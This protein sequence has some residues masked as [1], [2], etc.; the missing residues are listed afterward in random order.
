MNVRGSSCNIK[1][2]T[3]QNKQANKTHKTKQT[4]KK[5]KRRWKYHPFGINDPDQKRSEISSEKL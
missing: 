5:R 1:N 3:K 2:N 4:K